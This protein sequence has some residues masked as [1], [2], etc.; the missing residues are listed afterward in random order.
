M[1]YKKKDVNQLKPI[2]T[3]T[4]LNRKKQKTQAKCSVNGCLLYLNRITQW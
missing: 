3:K 2:G 1:K 4:N